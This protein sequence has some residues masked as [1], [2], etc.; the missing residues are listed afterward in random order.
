MVKM[1]LIKI[2]VFSPAMQLTRLLYGHS[3]GHTDAGMKILQP[4]ISLFLCSYH[5]KA[6]SLR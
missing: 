1:N 5:R 4:T 2:L 3:E 6:A